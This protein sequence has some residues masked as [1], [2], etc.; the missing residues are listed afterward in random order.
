MTRPPA[1]PKLLGDLDSGM[2]LA[3]DAIALSSYQPICS[4][5]RRSERHLHPQS[6][7]RLRRSGG[8]SCQ[9]TCPTPY[10]DDRELDLLITASLEEAKQ[11]DRLLPS[12]QATTPDESARKRSSRMAKSSHRRPVEVKW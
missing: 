4:R 11:R 7:S 3:W 9:R 5:R 8:M 12:V 1:V 2:I 6:R 10:L